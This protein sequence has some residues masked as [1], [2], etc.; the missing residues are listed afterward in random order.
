MKKGAK[1]L[2]RARMP[3][4][5]PTHGCYMLDRSE[6]GCVL[7]LFT[8]GQG[9]LDTGHGLRA[10]FHQMQLQLALYA[11]R[12]PR[13]DDRILY[14][15]SSLSAITGLP[16]R[17][18]GIPGPRE[19]ASAPQNHPRHPWAPRR[20]AVGRRPDWL[21]KSQESRSSTQCIASR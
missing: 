12:N 4:V 9:R 14:A 1:P 18:F 3:I 17:R 16:L 11:A 19:L 15:S 2:R 20:K 5:K 10:R 6:T 8:T 7:Q 21:A 13:T